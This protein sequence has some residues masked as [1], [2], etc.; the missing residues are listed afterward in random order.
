[1]RGVRYWDAVTFLGWL[2]AEPDK[3]DRCRAVIKLAEARR[4]RIVT[5]SL[6]LTEV[7]K[8][9]GKAPLTRDKESIIRDFFK[10]DYIIVRLLDRRTAEYGRELIWTHGFHPKDAIHVATAV[11][12]GVDQLDTFDDD[13]IKK[14]GI[15]GT[16]PLAIGK[17]DLPEQLEI[18][19]PK[20]ASSPAGGT[21][22]GEQAKGT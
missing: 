17:P 20:A 13:L 11:L 14:S 16:P 7:I 18:I 21:E 22:S 8:L 15:I 10:N 12:A 9:K 1:M 19:Y 5:S 4:V 3:V 6:T 2:A